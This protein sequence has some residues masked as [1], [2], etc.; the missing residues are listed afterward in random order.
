MGPSRRPGAGNPDARAIPAAPGP[1]LANPHPEIGRELAARI[2]TADQSRPPDRVRGV[3]CECRGSLRA[4]FTARTFRG[5]TKT[6]TSGSNAPSSLRSRLAP[7]TTT[8]RG[9]PAS[10]SSC[11][12]RMK[13]SEISAARRS[14]P[15]LGS[16]TYSARPRR[17]V[18]A[19][20]RGL[21]PGP[22]A[23]RRGRAASRPS[24]RAGAIGVRPVVVGCARPR[25]ASRGG[26]RGG[27]RRRR[28]ARH[29]IGRRPGYVRSGLCGHEQVLRHRPRS[30]S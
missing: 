27:S 11:L 16:A 29:G 8:S 21:V 26:K 13:S 2:R 30:G 17:H 5:S 23:G 12:T 3:P 19:A 9:C 7:A 18:V 25:P 24:I 28:E 15:I 4:A 1:R 20:A 6:Q 14:W 22:Q 10:W